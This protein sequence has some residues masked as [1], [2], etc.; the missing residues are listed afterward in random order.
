MRLRNFREIEYADPAKFRE[1]KD[2]MKEQE[3]RAFC[4]T[5]LRERRW[6]R[7]NKVKLHD[8]PDEKLYKKHLLKYSFLKRAR[9]VQLMRAKRYAAEK[10]KEGLE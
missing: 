8:I 5:Y 3:A 7:D 4:E 9:M 1:L 10:I 6:L 2:I